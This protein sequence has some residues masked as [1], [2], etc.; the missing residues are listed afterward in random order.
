MKYIALWVIMVI[1]RCEP[2]LQEDLLELFPSFTALK[3]KLVSIEKESSIKLKHSRK[4]SVC[5]HYYA[6][7]NFP[8]QRTEAFF[9]THVHLLW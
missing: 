4:F 6:F 8:K 1:L 3:I 5:I 7:L 2:T 9:F